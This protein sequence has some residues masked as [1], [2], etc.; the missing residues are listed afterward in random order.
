[1]NTQLKADIEAAI[2]K[3]IENHCEESLWGGFIHDT[4]IKQMTNACESVFDAAM[5]SQIYYSD[6]MG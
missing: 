1:M 2:N 6:Q 5:E 3:V 4:L